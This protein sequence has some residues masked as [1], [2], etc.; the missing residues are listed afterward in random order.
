MQMTRCT[1]IDKTAKGKRVES[2]LLFFHLDGKTYFVFY[3]IC[4]QIN[5]TWLDS[6][7]IKLILNYYLLNNHF[8]DEDISS[9]IVASCML[10][11]INSLHNELSVKLLVK[12][13][14]RK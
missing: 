4:K 1:K 5:L 11:Y 9:I 3:I 14:L 7:N 6:L 13:L 8:V 2:V 12:Y 10:T